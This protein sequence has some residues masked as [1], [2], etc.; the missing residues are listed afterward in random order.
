MYHEIDLD[1][2]SLSQGPP[3]EEPGRQYYFMAECRQAVK[4][5]E[6]KLGRRPTFFAQTFGCQMNARDSEKLSGILTSVG[7]APA[8][9][10]EADF[11]IYNTC[12]VR[13]NANN[14]VW[15]RLGYLNA[16]KKRLPHMKIALCGCMMQEPEVIEKLKKSYPF[17]SLVF[18]THNIYKFAELLSLALKQEEAVIDIWQETDKIVEDLPIERKYP[19][20]SG[21]N[22]MFGCNNFCSYCI[23][24]YVRG[25]ERSRRPEDIIR[26]IQDLAGD[27][28]AEVMLLGQNV[29]SYGKNL[30][31]PTTFADLL[32]EVER[33]EGISR[34]RFMTSHPKDLSDELIE[35]MCASK[36]I[37]RHLHLPLQSGSSRILKE[38]N[39]RY[40]KGQYLALVAKIRRA[41][42]DIAL[43]TDIIVGFP[44]ETEED[45][46][47]TMDVVRKVGF[48]SA[49][50][51]IYSK[52]T[53]TP[54]AAM[55]GQVP[56]DVV[57]ERF[58]RLL[59]EV[60]RIAAEKA[61]AFTG[62]IEPVLV[63]EVN[64]QDPRLV[65]G[66]MGN[67]F[68]VHLPGNEGMVGKIFEV[69][70]KEC[71]GFYFYGEVVGFSC[72]PIL[73]GN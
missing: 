47:E 68:V 32:R 23:V 51:F 49:F 17:V 7:Y 25:R 9:S 65:T 62:R 40:D 41:M 66:R 59:E 48:E 19:F 26:E 28:V 56:E 53:G 42:P 34:I 52:R 38:M 46:L 50:T 18:G 64:G 29:N 3:Q 43:T 60:Q 73:G 58:G 39:R 57:K 8:D 69:E 44:G 71:R 55:E 67:N 12:T 31:S 37:C 16:A 14:K 15:G 63:E 36:K 21:V 24:P 33:V 27:G 45:F 30:D 11:V 10:E 20:K 6:G 22:I 2:V 5:L 72:I 70:L 54:A 61:G 35:V 13:E 4:E 1:K